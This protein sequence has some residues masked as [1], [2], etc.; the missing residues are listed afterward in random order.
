MSTVDFAVPADA[1]DC[2]VHVF[3][4]DTERYP[5]VRKRR[6]TPQP[7]PVSDLNAYLSGL[8]LARVIV[9]QPSIYGTNNA[10]MLDTLDLLGADK[11]RGVAVIG[12]EISDARLDDM[13][14]RGVRG[15]RINLGMEEDTDLKL[16]AQRLRDVGDRIQRLGWHVQV[17]CTADMIVALAEALAALPV[18]VVFDHLGGVRADRGLDHPGFRTV[19]SLLKSGNAYV[20]ASGAYLCS[21]AGPDFADVAPFAQAVIAANPDRVLWGS[22]WPHPDGSRGPDPFAVRPFLPHGH[23][24]TL[25]QLGVWAPHAETRR[26]ILVDNPAR[27][28]GF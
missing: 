14:R 25:N 10:G 24:E 6:Y 23:A 16:S 11:A 12:G 21:D 8:G 1:C 26:K 9:V 22:N 17:F 18:P 5:F 3:P 4:E 2:H 13:H 20:K 7:A 15:V 19:L 27:L 28:Y